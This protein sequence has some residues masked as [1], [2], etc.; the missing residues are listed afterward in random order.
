[1]SFQCK[2][3]KLHK[4]EVSNLKKQSSQPCLVRDLSYPLPIPVDN[5]MQVFSFKTFSKPSVIFTT[6]PLL[7]AGNSPLTRLLPQPLPRSW[8]GVNAW[9]T[10]SKHHKVGMATLPLSLTSLLILS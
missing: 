7:C 2:L 8:S 3:P 6:C 5:A 9:A 10:S 4:E 1:M